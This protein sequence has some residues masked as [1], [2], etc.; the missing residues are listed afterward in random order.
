MDGEKYH[1]IGNNGGEFFFS[2]ASWGAWRR[3][4]EFYK[5]VTQQARL[6]RLVLLYTYPI[7]RSNCTTETMADRIERATGIRPVISTDCSGIISPTGDKAVVH[8]ERGGYWKAAGGKS[9]CGVRQEAEI[10]RLLAESRPKL[11][12]FSNI[13]DFRDTGMSVSFIM[14]E[15]PGAFCE[16][17]CATLAQVMPALEEFHGLLPEGLV[18]GDFKPWNVRWRKD[19]RPHFFDFEEAHMGDISEDIQKWDEWMRLC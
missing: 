8:L 16:K 2:M 1:I 15:E 7:L 14:S 19:G 4:L 11:F 13:S 9:Y 10:Y 17:Q 18:H 12:G 3:S 6:K 5:G